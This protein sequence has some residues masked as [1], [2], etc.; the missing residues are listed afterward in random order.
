MSHLPRCKSAERFLN[1]VA[2]AESAANVVQCEGLQRRDI[3]LRS[4]VR[5]RIRRADSEGGYE[6]C[7]QVG[8][9]T[10]ETAGEPCRQKG[11]LFLRFVICDSL[12]IQTVRT[13][14]RP[15][16]DTLEA[17]EI[18]DDIKE[19]SKDRYISLTSQKPCPEF[20]PPSLSQRAPR[21][22]RM[23]TCLRQER[24]KDRTNES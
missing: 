10:L 16:T 7:P 24:E 21:F 14:L 2:F 5:G 4:S 6:L 18:C 19:T 8:R 23:K 9:S 13:Q 11:Q 17:L 3:I 20:L 12:P 22:A 15:C 1:D